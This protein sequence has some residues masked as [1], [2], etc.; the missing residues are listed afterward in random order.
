[1]RTIVESG[2]R[3]VH[4]LILPR[5]QPARCRRITAATRRK[6]DEQRGSKAQSMPHRGERCVGHAWAIAFGRGRGK[7]VRYKRKGPPSVG[8]AALRKAEAKGVTLTSSFLRQ[9]Q[10]QRRLQQEQQRR[11]QVPSRQRQAQQRQQQEQQRR[12][13]VPSRQQQVLRWLQRQQLE[14]LLQQQ[15][16]NK[17]SEPGQKPERAKEQSSSC[18][19]T[20]L[21]QTLWPHSR[22]PDWSLHC[23]ARGALNVVNPAGNGFV[24]GILQNSQNLHKHEWLHRH[25]LAY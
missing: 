9:R 12:Q 7:Y 25:L 16:A 10:E 14:Q 18:G 4:R 3:A 11:Q 5:S 8:M 1:M 22:R 17:R 24:R 6:C 19:N 13:Q 15:A 21:K 20:P 23:S 2:G